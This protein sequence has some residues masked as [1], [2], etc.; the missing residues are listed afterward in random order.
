M[1]AEELTQEARYNKLKNKNKGEKV[2]SY[3]GSSDDIKAVFCNTSQYQ[4]YSDK[5]TCN[6]FK[7]MSSPVAAVEPKHYLKNNKHNFDKTSGRGFY[8]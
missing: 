7:N 3:L 4:T 5:I 8:A 1:S 2:N 6:N